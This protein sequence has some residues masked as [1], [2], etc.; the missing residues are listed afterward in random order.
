MADPQSSKGLETSSVESTV[1]E[2]RRKTRKKY[3]A[4]EKV[5]SVLEGLR[6]E[7]KIAEL[8]LR[9]GIHKTCTTNGSRNFWKQVSSDWSETQNAKLTARKWTNCAVRTS[10]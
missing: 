10:S 9:E 2:I 3:S 7:E 5:R 8:C 4:E 6:G 1:R